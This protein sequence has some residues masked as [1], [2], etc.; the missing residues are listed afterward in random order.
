MY[1]RNPAAMIEYSLPEIGRNKQD[2]ILTMLEQYPYMNEYWAGK[3]A[4]ISQ[5]EVPAYVLASF[6]SG[7]HATHVYKGKAI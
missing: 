2:D 7:L 5:I 4:R 6:S 1:F 3:R